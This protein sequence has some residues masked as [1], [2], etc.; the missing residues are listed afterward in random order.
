MAGL[1]AYPVLL[2]GLRRPGQLRRLVAVS[3][4]LSVAAPAR[5]SGRALVQLPSSS[6]SDSR[7]ISRDLCHGSPRLCLLLR[8]LRRWIPHSREAAPLLERP[9]NR[10]SS[11][12]P[13]HTVPRHPRRS[14][15]RT[16]ASRRTPRSSPGQVRV[17]AGYGWW[18]C[19]SPLTPVSSRATPVR[20]A[21]PALPGT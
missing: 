1:G 12:G 20:H 11:S 13:R 21:P 16:G 5:G 19:S 10:T 4:P 17:Q 14:D 9:P 15:H 2:G 7:G 3:D 6:H 18:T 8:R